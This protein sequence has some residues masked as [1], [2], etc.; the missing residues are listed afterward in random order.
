M[1]ELIFLIAIAFVLDLAV[2]DPRWMP[3]PVRLIGKATVGLEGA[4]THAFGR[5]RLPGAC[6]TAIIVGGAWLTVWGIIETGEYLDHRLAWALTVYILYTTISPRDM[7]R[8]ASRVFRALRAGNIEEARTSLAMI[9]GRDTSDLNE[10]EI[11]RASVESVAEGAVDGV[12]APLFFA[13]LGGAPLAMAYRAANTLDS[14]V[15]YRSEKYFAFG[16]ASA[17]LDDLLNYIPARLAR[18]LYPAAALVCGM[19]V[20]DSWRI[21]F[22][23]GKKSPSPNAAISEAAL[24]GAL[25]I[26]LG[27]VNI[28]QGVREERPRIG[29]PNR[30]PAPGDI[31]RAVLWMYASSTAG[32]VFFSGIR[33]LIE[34][35]T[36]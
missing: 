14:M 28:Y 23:D 22:R 4:L 35:I 24:A 18:L 7:D 30:E 15:G 36:T 8:H 1:D 3:H 21:S 17:R 2:G 13:I 34:A 6:L 26:Q 19:R 5:G 32:L 11:V 25:G 16:W 29:E 31:P 33:T 10:K 9:V 27:G 12:L 20:A